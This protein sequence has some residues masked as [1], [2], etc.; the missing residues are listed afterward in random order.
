MIQVKDKSFQPFIAASEIAQRVEAMG[1]ALSSDYEDKNPLFLVVLNGAFMFASDLFKNLSIPAEITFIRLKSYEEMQS[2]GKVKELLGL[3]ENIFNRHLVI[4]EDIVDTGKTMAHLK[5]ELYKL[6][7]A[8]IAV[9][10]LLTK[11]EALTVPMPLEYVGFEI[12]NKFVVGYGLDYDG[13]GRNL[14][15]LYQ[16]AE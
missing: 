9:A 15:L 3:S 7:P 16:L 5:E 8:S 10:T 1:K 11:P 2:S 13:H 6:G 12:P 4:V 14:P